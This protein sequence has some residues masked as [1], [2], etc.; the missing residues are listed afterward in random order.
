MEGV[1]QRAADATLLV[2]TVVL[3]AL[4]WWS[5]RVCLVPD[6]WAQGRQFTD[7][8]YTDLAPLWFSRGLADGTGPWGSEPLEYPVLLTAQAWLT[9]RLAH[10][11][12][13]PADVQD[14]LDV[15][16]VL[17][18]VQALGV[19]LLLRRAGVDVQHLAWWAAAP[20]LAFYALYNWDLLPALLLVG[21]IVAHREERHALSGTL[22]GLGAAAKLFPI[23]LVPLV[24]LALLRRR[25]PASAATHL[26]AAVAAWLAVNVPAYLAA[27]EAWLRFW[28][29]NRERAAHVDSLWELLHRGTGV[30]V[31]TE[32]LNV[33][34]PVLLAAGALLVVGL[35]VRRV[36]PDATWRLVLPL[37]VVFLLTNKVLS[38]QY[39]L[40]LVPLMVL[41]GTRRAPLLAAVLADVA[42]FAVE[43]PVLGGRAG[44]EP[45]LPY[46]AL[47]TAV[48]LRAAALVWV[49]A[50]ALRQDQESNHRRP[51]T[52]PSG[53]G[54]PVQTG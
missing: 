52:A 25:R 3:V 54:T 11:L 10:L 7:H 27:P 8:C 39:F 48:A 26:A 12:P 24:V 31:D 53:S 45:S 23:F 49:A 44:I 37:L 38:P 18:A 42:V 9:A 40:W 6:A 51:S 16:A 1:R 46:A 28:Q 34:G 30:S 20:A 32:A 50:D 13:G 35:G 21:A 43:L 36:P 4:S 5:K 33:L 17:A 15:N 22:A 41:C 14:F 29:L 2:G 47:G 19:L